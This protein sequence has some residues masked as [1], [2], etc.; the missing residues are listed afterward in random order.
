MVD[1]DTNFQN[2]AQRMILFNFLSSFI[3]AYSLL[4][5]ISSHFQRRS[6]AASAFWEIKACSVGVPCT[7]SGSVYEEGS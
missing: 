4:W 2:V 7:L 6:C 5:S 3:L 1:I